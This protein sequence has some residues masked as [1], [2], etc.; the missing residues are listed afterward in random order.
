MEKRY[1]ITYYCSDS[2]KVLVKTC[3]TFEELE[4]FRRCLSRQTGIDELDA[5]E[6]TLIKVGSVLSVY[7]MRRI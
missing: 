7:D 4:I 6:F 3:K 5:K 2:D 1:C